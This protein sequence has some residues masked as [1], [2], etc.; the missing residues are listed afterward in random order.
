M[1]SGSGVDWSN[2]AR[3]GGG[4]GFAVISSLYIARLASSALKD[5]EE[6]EQTKLSD[7]EVERDAP[8]K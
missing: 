1:S 7:V 5:V 2:V 6:L 4:F 8:T 3:V